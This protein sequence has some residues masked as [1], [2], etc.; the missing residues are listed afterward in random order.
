MAVSF[1]FLQQHHQNECSRFPTECPNQDC[2]QVLPRN[3][4]T[5]FILYSS[6]VQFHIQPQMEIFVHRK[7]H[8]CF[9]SKNIEKNECQ[10]QEVPCTYSDIG[11]DVKVS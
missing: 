3:E 2:Q 7:N 11:C 1:S 8:F 9:R 4:V 5:V 10:Q 6:F